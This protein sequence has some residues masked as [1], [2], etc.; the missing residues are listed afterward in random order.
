MAAESGKVNHSH[1]GPWYWIWKAPRWRLYAA[2]A[3]MP[4]TYQ[5]RAIA[6]ELAAYYG[7]TLSPVE[8]DDLYDAYTAMPRGRVGRTTNPDRYVLAFHDLPE[9]LSWPE[10]KQRLVT[11]FSLHGLLDRVVDQYRDDHE[12]RIPAHIATAES[13]LGIAI[14]PCVAYPPDA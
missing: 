12:T 2:D 14:P 10:Q 6:D 5:W 9:G 7:V 4:H 1:V 8:R 11:D 3:D 13:L